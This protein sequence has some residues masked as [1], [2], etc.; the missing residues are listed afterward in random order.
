MSGNFYSYSL[1]LSKGQS[2]L[3]ALLFQAL[4]NP[5]CSNSDDVM[6]SLIITIRI[7]DYQLLNPIGNQMDREQAM[8]LMEIKRF[9]LLLPY[10]LQ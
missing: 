4:E 2:S 8:A 5:M 3:L 9:L 6:K 1:S 10:M 7:Q